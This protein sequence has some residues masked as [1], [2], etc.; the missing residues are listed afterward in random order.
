M[1][2]SPNQA[3]SPEKGRTP[4]NFARPTSQ[5]STTRRNPTVP[6]SK[7]HQRP[8]V[9]RES[10]L[11]VKTSAT[12]SHS[13]ESAT[14]ASDTTNPVIIETT[15]WGVSQSSGSIFFDVTSRRE[16]DR[17]LYRLAY[18]QF[19]DYVGLVV[20]K[21]G[22]NRYLEINF[23]NKEFRNAACN[24]GFKF[25]NGMII[26]RPVVA[27]R[28]GS[29]IKRVT[30]QRLPWL[31][32]QRLLEG[33]RNTL[34]NYGIVRDVGIV[35][36]TETG[37]F[38]G[39]GYAILDC[40][41]DPNQTDPFLELTHTIQWVDLD[42]NGELS[43]CFIHAYWK[44]M[45]TY[46]KY[47]HEIGHS[48]VECKEAPSN[49]RKCFYCYKA[50]HIRAQCPEK[51]ALGKRRKGASS[52]SISTVTTQPSRTPPSSTAD[53]VLNTTENESA[54]TESSQQELPSSSETAPMETEPDH[55]ASQMDTYTISSAASASD[56]ATHRSKYAS[57]DTEVE[58]HVSTSMVIDEEPPT[59]SQ[60]P[61]TRDDT[62]TTTETMDTS[63]S[64]EEA[65]SS[66]T[67]ND[68]NSSSTAKPNDKSTG[69]FA[70]NASVRKSTRTPKP[71]TLINL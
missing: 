36:D 24:D 69:K 59:T 60:E 40:S 45:P 38:I 27:C 47:C 9:T 65:T 58:T 67:A 44:D 35:T 66:S 23:D 29:I 34:N 57:S 62:S 37:A 55:I 28:P 63:S 14:T 42:S 22:P 32:P 16:S 10:L 13:V 4:N 26:V 6:Y 48:A 5:T 71:R 2:L 51:V 64:T 70:A 1:F 50:G 8:A 61:I 41:P 39:S 25:D 49:K 7:A 54:N 68:G 17:E 11:H 21:S 18:Y 15:Y 30:L 19:K 53:S 31:R 43:S 3:K 12:S 20:H 56:G 33:L 46:C 52:A